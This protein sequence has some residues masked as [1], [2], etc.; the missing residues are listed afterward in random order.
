MIT[1]NF[2]SIAVIVVNNVKFLGAT[3]T[4]LVVVVVVVVVVV[5]SKSGGLDSSIDKTDYNVVLSI[6]SFIFRYSDDASTITSADTQHH[7][8]LRA[9]EYYYYYRYWEKEGI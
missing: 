1:D 6:F 8:H 3:T 5:D 7:L 9:F 2:Q 4:I